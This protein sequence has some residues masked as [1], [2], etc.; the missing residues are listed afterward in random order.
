MRIHPEIVEIIK[1]PRGMFQGIH[2]CVERQCLVSAVALI[3]SCIDSLAALTRPPNQPDT[4]R[5]EFINWVNR[6]LIPSHHLS[7]SA[8]DIYGARCG[9]LH[10]Y[11]PDS[12]M[13]RK[14]QAQALVYYWK[15]GPP[16]NATIP[17]PPDA[18]II[19]LED[20]I[21]TLEQAVENFLTDIAVDDDLTDRVY[22][23]RRELLCY[24]PYET[25]VIHGAA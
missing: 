12:R 23:N 4:T 24:K 3:Y 18:I 21:S 1:G 20:L 19:A 22:H 16:P 7:C 13:R 10:T 6:Y 9:I 8:E 15:S 14:G 2:A 17:L 11:S 5:V 25:I